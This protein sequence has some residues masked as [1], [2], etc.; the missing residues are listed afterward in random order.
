MYYGTIR[1]VYSKRR[2]RHTGGIREVGRYKWH[3]ILIILLSLAYISVK[4]AEKDS[5]INNKNRVRPRKLSRYL[6]KKS[7]A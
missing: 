1:G 6:Y 5:A 2:Q 3:F 4:V 7:L